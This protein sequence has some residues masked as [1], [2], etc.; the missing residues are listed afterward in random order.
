MCFVRFAGIAPIHECSPKK[1][2]ISVSEL[3]IIDWLFRGYK[4]KVKG[5]N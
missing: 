5:H 3:Q 4:Y 1:G 2:S